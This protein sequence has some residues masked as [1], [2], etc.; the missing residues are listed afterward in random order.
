MNFSRYYIKCVI[1]ITPLLP[2]EM[3]KFVMILKNTFP[4]FLWI[5]FAKL[6]HV[7]DISFQFLIFSFFRKRAIKCF[8][9]KTKNCKRR[10]R[11]KG[12]KVCQF[13]HKGVG[14]VTWI[15]PP[16]PPIINMKFEL[17]CSLSMGK[18]CPIK[19]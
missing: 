6:N 7:K 12:E 16:P 3:Q 18:R 2:Q 15:R 9:M 10:K 1:K 11:K 5:F 8:Q 17:W 4:S 14:W 19:L 13:H